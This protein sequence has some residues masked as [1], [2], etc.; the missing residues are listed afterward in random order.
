VLFVY[1]YQSL[2]FITDP[3]ARSKESPKSEAAA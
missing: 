3:L 2:E 1:R